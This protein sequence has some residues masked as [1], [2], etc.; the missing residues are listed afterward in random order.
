MK[1]A[2][3]LERTLEGALDHLAGR[4]FRGGLH[5]SELSARVAREAEL[6]E[7]ATPVGPGTANR[8]QLTINPRSLIGDPA[9]IGREL[10]EALARHAA[11]RGWLLKGPAEVIVLLDSTVPAGSAQC[12]GEVFH[13]PIAPWAQLTVTDGRRLDVRPNRAT[14]GRAYEA[15]VVVPFPEVSR[16]HALIYRRD[17]ESYVTDFGSVNGTFVDGIRVGPTPVRIGSGSRLRLAEVEL[18]FSQ[19]PTVY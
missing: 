4:L 11:E 13:G 10:G 7:F 17:G 9:R 18:R 2:R 15:D 14:I 8:Y 16:R 12:T 19:L 5:N 1:L 3:R 6:A